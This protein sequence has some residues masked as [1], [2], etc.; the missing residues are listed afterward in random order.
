[1][2][3]AIEENSEATDANRL[4]RLESESSKVSEQKSST[5]LS[6]TENVLTNSYNLLTE[7]I[8]RN[9]EAL[10]LNDDEMLLEQNDAYKAAK[11]N[12]SWATANENQIKK[13]INDVQEN[14]RL[15]KMRKLDEEKS[16]AT[17]SK[18]GNSLIK[19][20]LESTGMDTKGLRVS[21]QMFD[22]NYEDA[23]KWLRKKLIKRYRS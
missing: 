7:S 18:H 12:L 10:Q 11:S 8:K 17:S 20:Y 22:D 16:L 15:N 14:F 6:S 23:K 2:N 3:Q 13:Q 19:Q 5:L 1:M 4:K 9:E 21:Q